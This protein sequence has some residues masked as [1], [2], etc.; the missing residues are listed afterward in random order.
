MERTIRSGL[1]AVALL[2]GGLGTASAQSFAC[3]GRLTID[4]TAVCDDAALREADERVAAAYT[5]LLDIL[6]RADRG[7]IPE[8]RRHQRDFLARLGC[9]TLQGFLYS[10][11]LPAERIVEYLR[12][13]QPTRLNG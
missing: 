4:E 9:D 2:A 10:K 6:K 3:M 7:F 13:Y 8:I 11:P 1:L 5:R 12:S